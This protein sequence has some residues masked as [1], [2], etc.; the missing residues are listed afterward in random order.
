MMKKFFLVIIG[1]LLIPLVTATVTLEVTGFSCSPNEVVVANQFTCTATVYNSGTE[2]GSLTEVVLYSDSSNWL[3]AS[4]YSE[5]VN[6]DIGSGASAEV[7]FENLRAQKSGTY[8]FSRINLGEV[9]DTYPADN[10]VEVNVV[11]IVTIVTQSANSA[12]ASTGTVDATG[13]VNV[14]GNLDLVMTLSIISGGCTIGSQPSYASFND[15]TDGQSV[16][17]TWTLTMGVRNCNYKISSVAT[18]NPSGIASKTDSTSKT[19]T[20]TGTTCVTTSDDDDTPPPSSSSGGGG[21]GG[22][23]SNKTK[24]DTNITE[25]LQYAAEFEVGEE[26]VVIDLND[27][28]S[29]EEEGKV[30]FSN[31][32]EGTIYSFTFVNKELEESEWLMVVKTINEE[33]ETAVFFLKEGENV[34]ADIVNLA[35]PVEFDLDDD[36]VVDLK[37][38]LTKIGDGVI[39]FSVEKSESFR[40]QESEL[41]SKQKKIIWGIII[42]TSVL[43]VVLVSLIVYFHVKKEK[44]VKG[45]YKK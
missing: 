18:S 34:K 44:I 25:V 29:W 21:G 1:I 41:A 43:V 39:D 33:S 12:A 15:V 4:S 32:A 17:Y 28:S 22:T 42:V 45:Y 35:E 3:E 8:G 13:Q 38:T 14:G 30:D 19:I 37:I 24:D 31:V 9:T 5:I 2:S 6:V 36:G 11:D 40:T 20:C 16:S 26:D 27:I 7:V 23:T 10:N